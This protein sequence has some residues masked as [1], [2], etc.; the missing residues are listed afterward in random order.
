MSQNTSTITNAIHTEGEETRKLIT[1]NTIQNL[2]DKLSEK[3]S[4]LQSAQL[5]LANSVQTNNILNTLG[6]FVPYSGCGS[7]CGNGS[8]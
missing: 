6:R 2:R 5:T 4:E 8:F 3:D 1:G 7:V